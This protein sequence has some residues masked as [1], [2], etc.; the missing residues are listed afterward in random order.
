MSNKR[1]GA[2]SPNVS[3]PGSSVQRSG[4]GLFGILL[5]LLIPPLGLMF[6]WRKGVFRTR[7]RVLVTA[8]ATVEMAVVLAL[9]MP[10]DAVSPAPPVPGYAERYTPAPESEVLT[11]LSNMDELLRQQQAADAGETYVSPI[12]Q[13]QMMA[14]QQAILDSVVYAVYDSGARYYHSV[15]VCGNQSNLRALTVQ[16]AL[17]DGLSPCPDCDPP[18]YSALG[19]TATAEPEAE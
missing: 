4:R 11:A 9:M 19:L 13:Q 8:L 14:E 3:M 15:T 12:D 18:T 6:L 10:N 2:Y 17:A 7:G 16:E 5:C 1:R